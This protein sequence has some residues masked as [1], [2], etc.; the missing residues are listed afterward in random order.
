MPMKPFLLRLPADVHRRL[1]ILAAAQEVSMKAF[2]IGKI[3][4]DEKHLDRT[5]ES[6]SV[7]SPPLALP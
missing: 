4:E 1:K 5:S 2:L 7:G 3:L 6:T